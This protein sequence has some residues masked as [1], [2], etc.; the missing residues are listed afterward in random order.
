MPKY[1]G[2][3]SVAPINRCSDKKRLILQNQKQIKS[4]ISRLCIFCG[5]DACDPV[6]IIRQSDSIALQDDPAN[7]VPGCRECH[8]TFDNGDVT[9]LKNLDKV[10]LLMSLLDYQYYL[11]FCDK[12]NV[13][14]TH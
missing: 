3:K 4:K 14:V 10:L 13:V 12:R 11:R 5:M 9:T 1:K 2:R 8:N 6:H 7:I